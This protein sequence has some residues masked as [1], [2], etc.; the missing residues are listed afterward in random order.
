MIQ[1]ASSSNSHR[2]WPNALLRGIA[3]AGVTVTCLALTA[4]ASAEESA[5]GKIPELASSSFAWLAFGVHWLDPP[6][7]LRGPIRQD[8]AHPFHGNLDGPG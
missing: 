8:P 4:P 2:F 5:K 1:H 6:T 7:G 3:A